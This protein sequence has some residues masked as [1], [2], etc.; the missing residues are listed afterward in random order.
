MK[1]D[2]DTASVY[3]EFISYL[4]K[5]QRRQ[6]LHQ[7]ASWQKYVQIHVSKLSASIPAHTTPPRTTCTA[8][9]P[10]QVESTKKILAEVE[11]RK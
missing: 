1:R 2:N 5:A 6:P 3:N 9:I 11:K 10:L 7:D 4:P 8:E